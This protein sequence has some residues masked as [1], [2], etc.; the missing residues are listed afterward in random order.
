M[1]TNLCTQLYSLQSAAS[2]ITSVSGVGMFN[3]PRSET[4]FIHGMYD[5]IF[6]STFSKRFLHKRSVPSMNG[7]R[8]RE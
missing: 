5:F 3:E 7:R 6:V 2:Y 1:K 4:H 8:T